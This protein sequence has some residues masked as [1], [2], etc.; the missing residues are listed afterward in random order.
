MAHLDQ[1]LTQPLFL[2]PYSLSLYKSNFAVPSNFSLPCEQ[3]ASPTLLSGSGETNCSHGTFLILSS[4]SSVHGWCNGKSTGSS[5]KVAHW[6]D[7]RAQFLV[8]PKRNILNFLFDEDSLDEW[9]LW[10]CQL[11]LNSFILS[12]SLDFV[13][14]LFYFLQNSENHLQ[15]PAKAITKIAISPVMSR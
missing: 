8:S 15:P 1:P 13:I 3:L 4:V 9:A 11:L 14:H 5:P 12:G 10:P 7:S 6:L 2:L